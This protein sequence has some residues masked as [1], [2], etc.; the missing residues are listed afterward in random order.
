M[1]HQV[2]LR[3]ATPTKKSGERDEIRPDP[4]SNHHH[5]DFL[6]GEGMLVTTAPYHSVIPKQI[7]HQSS[8]VGNYNQTNK[9]I[10]VNHQT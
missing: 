5:V 4:Y 10:T 6:F 2:H 1:S 7:Y 3:N 9:S 8:F